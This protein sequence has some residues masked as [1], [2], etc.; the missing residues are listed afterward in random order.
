MDGFDFHENWIIG[1]LLTREQF[2]KFW[3]VGVR[4]TC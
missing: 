2:A 4:V 1:S 3:K